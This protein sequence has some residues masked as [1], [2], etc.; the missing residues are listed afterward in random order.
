MSKPSPASIRPPGLSFS[1]LDECSEAKPFGTA[2]IVV[3]IIN[4][5]RSIERMSVMRGRLRQLTLPWQRIAAIDGYGVS[6]ERSDD[7]DAL[8][9]RR[10]HGKRLNPAEVGCYLSHVKSLRKFLASDATFALILEDDA[11]FPPDFEELLQQLRIAQ[12]HWDIVKLS[13]FHSG[14]PVRIKELNAPYALAIPLS[15]HMN[16]NSILFNRKAAELLVSRLLPMYLPYDH[17]LEMA[18]L[19]GLRLRMVTPSPCPAETGL[20]ST[21]GDRRHLQQFK[22]PLY[23]RIPAMLFRLKTETMRLAFSLVQLAREAKKRSASNR[24]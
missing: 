15:R 23:R 11:D 1:S 8:G 14:T 12:D 7:V 5:D 18:W 3:L 19:Y 10:C 6:L 17:A 16:A 22:F 2:D 4:L 20:T 13:G 9:Y 21:I 24:R